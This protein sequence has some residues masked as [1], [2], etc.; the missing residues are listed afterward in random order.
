MASFSLYQ[1]EKRVSY[2]IHGLLLHFNSCQEW[3]HLVT[4]SSTF[5]E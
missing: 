1:N 4:I 3:G 5:Y 2:I